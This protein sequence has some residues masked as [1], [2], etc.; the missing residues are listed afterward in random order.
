[1]TGDRRTAEVCAWMV[2]HL[3]EPMTIDML[4]AKAFL[5]R[6]QFTRVF[7]AE[8]GR[9]PWQ[10]LL[11]ERLRAARRLL[12]CT[13]VPVDR[14]AQRCGFATAVSFRMHFR[15]AFATNPSSYRAGAMPVREPCWAA[16]RAS[17]TRDRRPS[18]ASV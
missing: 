3:E 11:A 17:A 5:G 7:R 1:M 13:S 6:R 14:V 4:A 10:W 9:T 8:T 15:R 12:E 2:D 16:A 18:L